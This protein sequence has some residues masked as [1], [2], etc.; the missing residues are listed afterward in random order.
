MNWWMNWAATASDPVPLRACRVA[1]RF[2]LTALA[3]PPSSNSTVASRNDASP[4][5]GRYSL[6][7]LAA[8]IRSSAVCT[9]FNTYGWSSSVR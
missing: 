9:T 5:I 8:S 2:S 6:F 7:S 1:T 4:S 3:S